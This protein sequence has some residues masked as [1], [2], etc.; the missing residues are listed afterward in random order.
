LQVGFLGGAREVG[1]IG[2]TVKSE[3]SKVV[4]DYGV[5]LDHEPGFP[6]HVPP[7]EVD[8]VILTHSHLDHSGAIPMF[9]INDKK[10]LYTNRLN[11]ELTQVLIQDF[12]HL[13]GYYLPFEYLELDAMMHNNRH[14]DFGVEEAIG[15]MKIKLFDAGHTP[16]SA[17]VLVEADGKK[18]LYTGDYN[19]ED[20]KLLKG[21]TMDYGDLDAVVTESTYASE[22]HTPRPEL[23]RGFVEAATEVVERGGTV[24]VPAFGVGRAQEIAC[25][26]AAN[27]FEHPVV[28]D[29]MAR[30]ASRIMMNY[31]EFLRDPRLFMNA[32]HSLEWVDGWRD[33]RRAAKDPGVIISPAGMLKGGPSQF[34]ISKIGKKANNA[35]FLVSYQIPGTPGKQL[36]DKGI[37]TIDGK[38]S[39]VKA[40]YRHF[41]FSSHCGASQLKEGL[42][43]LGGKPKVFA[44]H[45]AEGNCELLANWAKTELGLDAVAPRTGEIYEV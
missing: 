3:K 25:V 15:N 32:I 45:G 20:S 11:L 42:R 35:I 4:L 38:V 9:Y 39:K 31:K 18:I 30:E 29:G 22:D 26:L 19:M 12:I 13:S 24:L 16:G 5:M 6:M 34:Y 2:I 17:Q 28:L 21:A 44:V 40:Q 37:T 14:L 1:R 27:H 8:A 41:D 10:P 7:K 23:E 36:L 43:R 33:R